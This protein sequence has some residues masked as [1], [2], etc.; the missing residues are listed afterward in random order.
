MDTAPLE[1]YKVDLSNRIIGLNWGVHNDLGF[2]GPQAADTAI[3][4]LMFKEFGLKLQKKQDSKKCH[5]FSKC[6]KG[7]II[8]EYWTIERV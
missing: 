4:K 2:S 1:N 5:C 7:E 3:A 6:C 8:T